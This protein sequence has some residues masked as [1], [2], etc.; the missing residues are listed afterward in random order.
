[1]NK[2][3]VSSCGTIDTEGVGLLQVRTEP[4]AHGP[5]LTEH[6]GA[7]VSVSRTRSGGLCKQLIGWR[8]SQ[9]RPRPGGDSFPDESRADRVAP[10]HREAPRQR[11][12]DRYRW[13]LL[14]AHRF[15]LETLQKGSRCA[16][17]ASLGSRRVYTLLLFQECSSSAPTPD[18][19]TPSN[20]EVRMKITPEGTRTP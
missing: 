10:L 9:L 5:Q 6:W 4:R 18:L 20:G 7:F 12:C 15:E 11:E 16:A 19:A 2:L 8:C 13:W 3:Y 17:N 1:M 14:S